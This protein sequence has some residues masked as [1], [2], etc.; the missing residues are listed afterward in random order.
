MIG[1]MSFLNIWAALIFGAAQIT[2]GGSVTGT[3]RLTGG[4]PAAG[5]R[6]MAMV[7]PG[8]GR[9]GGQSSVLASL[10]ET[11]KNG[12][13]ELENIPPGRYFIAAGQ[14]ASPTFYPGT[15]LQNE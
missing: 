9:G 5:V 6:V 12:R 14:V 13:Y 7:A 3:V 2:A 10:A 15:L 8:A 11:D 1:V 4:A